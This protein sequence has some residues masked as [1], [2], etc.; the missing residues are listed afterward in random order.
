MVN[1]AE[2]K[3]LC[4]DRSHI[5]TAAVAKRVNILGFAVTIVVGDD[6]TTYPERRLDN[7]PGSGSAAAALCLFKSENIRSIWLDKSLSIRKVRTR[8]T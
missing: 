4:T 3:K 1:E 2:I 7:V 8:E 6:S 5:S